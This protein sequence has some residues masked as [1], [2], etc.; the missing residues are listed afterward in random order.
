MRNNKTHAIGGTGDGL[1]V[2]QLRGGRARETSSREVWPGETGVDARDM[3]GGTS[4]AL[5]GQG[6]NA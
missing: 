1:R 6:D 3:G 2:P 5:S 4:P